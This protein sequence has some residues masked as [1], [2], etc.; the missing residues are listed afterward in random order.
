MT[1]AAHGGLDALTGAEVT[2]CG[3]D[4]FGGFPGVAAEDGDAGAGVAQPQCDALVAFN[5]AVPVTS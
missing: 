5:L 4:A 3:A 2:G 1:S